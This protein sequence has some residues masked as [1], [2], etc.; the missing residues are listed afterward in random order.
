MREGADLKRLVLTAVLV[1]LG[2]VVGGGCAD[3]DRPPPD[4]RAYDVDSGDLSLYEGLRRAGLTV[5]ECMQDG[6]RYAL[7]DNGLGYYY[8]IYLKL[9]SP[10]NC[11]NNFLQANEMRDLSQASSFGGKEAEQ[12]LLYREPWMDEEIIHRLEWGIGSEEI[13]QK[14]GMGNANLY[15]VDALVQQV[16]N[17]ADVRAYVYASRGG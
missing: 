9:E 11:M 7:V 12:P 15:S 10:V 2:V 17:S 4:P 16:P 1:L 6:L 5:P 8:K 3:Q 14:F 13:F